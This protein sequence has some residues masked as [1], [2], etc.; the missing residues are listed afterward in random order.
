MKR[1]LWLLLLCTG[2]AN[3]FSHHQTIPQHTQHPAWS[4]VDEPIDRQALEALARKLEKAEFTAQN[5]KSDMGESQK[6]RDFSDKA[7]P[8]PFI[9]PTIYHFRPAKMVLSNPEPEY[10]MFPLFAKLWRI[11]D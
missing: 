7:Q 1:L 5:S 11:F 3:G 4:I 10:P 2:M 8:D 6:I 9:S